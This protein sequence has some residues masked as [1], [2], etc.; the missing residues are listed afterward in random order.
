MDFVRR[1]IDRRWRF[2]VV[3]RF[4]WWRRIDRR[5]RFV[6]VWRFNWWRVNGSRRDIW[7]RFVHWRND[8]RFVNGCG[9]RW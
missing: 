9:F 6:V 4:N 8:R 3:W 7:R 2:V 1:R 5:W